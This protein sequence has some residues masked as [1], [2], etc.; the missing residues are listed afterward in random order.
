MF[1]SGSE[2]G[3]SGVPPRLD[4]KGSRLLLSE[5]KCIRDCT[6][7]G[8]TACLLR[9]WSLVFGGIGVGVVDLYLVV[10]GWELWTFIWWCWGG[11]C[12]P[13]FGGIGDC[14]PLEG[15]S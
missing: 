13:S 3:V 1:P 6:L 7:D 10:L 2:G 9:T 15:G 12:G 11:G 5:L 8:H 14:E 4:G